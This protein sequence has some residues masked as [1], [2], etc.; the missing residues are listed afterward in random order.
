MGLVGPRAQRCLPHRRAMTFASA[1]SGSNGRRR[2]CALAWKRP[3]SSGRS[4]LCLSSLA[5]PTPV[6][7]HLPDAPAFMGDRLSFTVSN[8]ASRRGR[9][10]PNESST[11]QRRPSVADLQ[12]TRSSAS[13]N[14]APSHTST[15]AG[16][17]APRNRPHAS[18]W[19]VSRGSGSV[20]GRTLLC[21]VGSRC[22]LS[23]CSMASR[24]AACACKLF[25]RLL[26][27]EDYRRECP[28]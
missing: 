2:C 15:R 25:G 26:V 18:R 8:F 19:S 13:G 24:F 22:C 11:R 9:A 10:L 4:R 6:A 16:P 17:G 7:S 27:C 23:W 20:T 28:S 21:F 5:C 3:L 1:Y 12:A 14:Q